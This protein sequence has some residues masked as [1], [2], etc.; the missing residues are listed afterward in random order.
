MGFSYKPFKP[1][2]IV[3]DN[4]SFNN[5]NY[6][7]NNYDY[8]K[9]NFNNQNIEVVDI[10]VDNSDTII[11]FKEK[12]IEKEGIP[13]HYNALVNREDGSSS[14]YENG[15]F[16]GTLCPKSNIV[17]KDGKCFRYDA[18]NHMLYP[19][20]IYDE[21]NFKTNQYGA[22][23]MTMANSFEYYIQRPEIWEEMQKYYPVESFDSEADAYEFYERY[24]NVITNSGCGYAAATDI[25]FDEFRGREE[26][27]FETF[28]F[29]MYYVSTND[30]GEA[31]V[32]Y[33]YE[34]LELKLFNYCNK[35]KP[36]EEMEKEL[37]GGDSFFYW[38]FHRSELDN[39]PAMKGYAPRDYFNEECN[40]EIVYEMDDE[41][42]VPFFK[43]DDNINKTL[44][45]EYN[46]NDYLLYG[47]SGYD[48][49]N[50]DGTLAC[51]DGGSHYMLIVGWTEDNKPIVTSWGQKF[52]LDVHGKGTDL[53]DTYRLYRYNTVYG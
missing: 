2:K 50:M 3:F 36:L 18:A 43:S 49:Y 46:N 32:N 40:F 51:T 12:P 39:H 8:D 48:L 44:Y 17:L 21:E 4:F 29:S 52:V 6:S 16:V 45:D 26:A 5:G 20:S 27:F 7:H 24:F 19:V 9:S 30:D 41:N 31:Y 38:L 10:S 15:H 47:G 35:D 22:D 23:Q 37:D 13:F 34:L 42:T 14:L 28:G 11:P 25:I 53:S 33:N 1:E